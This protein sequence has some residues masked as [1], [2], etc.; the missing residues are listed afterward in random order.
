MTFILSSDAGVA[1]TPR[2]TRARPWARH[3]SIDVEALAA[4]AWGVQQVDRFERMGLHPIE[5]AAAGYEPRSY[6]GDG[7]GQLMAINNLGCRVDSGGVSVSDVV[8]PVAYAVAQAARRIAGDDRQ[9]ADLV[10]S[11]ALAGTRPTTWRPPEHRVR[12][13]EWAYER[14]SAV[15]EYQGPGRKGGYCQVLYLWD[16]SREAWGRGLYRRWWCGLEA[17]AWEMSKEALGFLVT[18]PAA[19]L[20]PWEEIGS[21][22][23]ISV[24]F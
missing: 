15:V 2:A 13:A 14:Q 24:D 20:E 23:P 16:A 7:V 18:G 8:H 9:A 5:A 22:H 11:H 19:P 17:L 10:R 4:W 21:K 3:G 6:S 12:P 1:A